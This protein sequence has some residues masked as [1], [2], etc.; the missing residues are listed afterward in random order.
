MAGIES[1]LRA[2]LLA[3]ADVWISFVFILFFLSLRFFEFSSIETHH[4]SFLIC[5]PIA[6]RQ[7]NCQIPFH[8]NI[9]PLLL[10]AQSSK[11][12]VPPYSAHTQSLLNPRLFSFLFSSWTWIIR[13]GRLPCPPSCDGGPMPMAAAKRTA[14]CE[15]TTRLLFPR[16][17]HTR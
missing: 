3:P 5:I 1:T 11:Q 17:S 8:S 9:V 12:D 14:S 13:Q 6:L 10:G 2:L 15:K 7:I 16:Q 4:L